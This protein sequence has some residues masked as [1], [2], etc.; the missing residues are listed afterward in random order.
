MTIKERQNRLHTIAADLKTESLS[1]IDREFLCEALGKIANGE[2]A[3][4]ALDVKARRG[5][6]TSKASHEAQK[7]SDKRL[8]LALGWIAA[9]IAPEPEG[10]GLT[11]EGAIAR[12][13]EGSVFGKAFGFT[14]ETLK[15]YWTKYPELHNEEMHFPD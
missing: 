12:I 3:K 13:V 1:L 9:A 15:T 10:Y 5:E 4:T 2:D 8:I 7:T 6:R 14:E 11:I